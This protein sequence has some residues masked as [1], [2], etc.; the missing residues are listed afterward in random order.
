[1]NQNDEL[2]AGEK[3]CKFCHTP[4]QP[5][6]K[7]K[8]RQYACGK[9]ICQL[10]RQKINQ[11]E[12]LAKNPVDYEEWYQDYGIEWNQKNPD[13]QKQYRSKNKNS[14]ST[15]PPDV[16]CSDYKIFKTTSGSADS[17]KKE[18]LTPINI[19]STICDKKKELTCCYYVLKARGLELFQLDLD[20]K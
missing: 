14:K 4:F 15:V 6:P 2:A 9:L 1:M 16:S 13:Y 5:H 17:D 18:E 19:N 7:V 10:I 8:D 20:K 3:I 11:I 12:C